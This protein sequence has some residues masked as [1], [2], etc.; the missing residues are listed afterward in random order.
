MSQY[1]PI[2]NAQRAYFYEGHTLSVDFRLSQL[3]KLLAVV[4]ANEARCYEAIGKDLQKS[5]FETYETELAMLYNDIHYFLKNLPKLAKTR[6]L[7][8][9]W[10]NFPAKTTTRPH[11]FGQACI[12]GPWNYPLQLVLIP[13]ATAI[14]AGNTVI[15]KPS[16][17]SPHCSGL[18]EELIN[19]TFN[20]EYIKVIQG[21]AAVTTEILANPFDKVFFTGST[22]VGSIITQNCAPYLPSITLELGGKS[23]C[24]VTANANIKEAAKKIVWGKL[25]NSGQTCIAPDYLLVEERVKAD[26]LKALKKEATKRYGEHTHTS[27]D[28]SKIINARHY[29]RLVDLIPSQNVIFGGQH[30]EGSLKID[31]TIIDH[32]QP[33]DKIM[34]SEIFGPLFPVQTF[35]KLT[36]VLPIVRQNADPL[37]LYLFSD[38]KGEQKLITENLNFG[39]CTINDVIMHVTNPYAPFGGVGAS[40]TGAYHAKH[41]FDDFSHHKPVLHKSSKALF[42]VP[43]RYAPYSAR[44]FKMLKKVMTWLD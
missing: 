21:D 20:P 2:F 39:G 9:N 42:D 23:P 37:A 7:G 24:I 40:G 27:K 26:L 13:L 25:L 22:A 31:F 4:S 3:E 38:D 17:L 19:K 28:V 6:K 8:T 44:K 10:L 14:A 29:Q 41:G 36:D 34:Q 1:A 12:I 11:P 33:E 15:L 5:P 32:V 16:E 18:I 43:L 35:T 30:D